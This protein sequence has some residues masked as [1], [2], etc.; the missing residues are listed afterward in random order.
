MKLL[1]NLYICITKTNN[2]N[3]N[4]NNNKLNMKV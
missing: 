1:S 4:N 3:N 2:N